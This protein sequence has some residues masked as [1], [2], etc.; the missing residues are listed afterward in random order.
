MSRHNTLPLIGLHSLYCPQEPFNNIKSYI[1]DTTSNSYQPLWLFCWKRGGGGG[2]SSFCLQETVTL[3][4]ML[5]LMTMMYIRSLLLV[6]G[7]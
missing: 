5:T 2:I 7:M 1:I 3:L 6:G 4:V